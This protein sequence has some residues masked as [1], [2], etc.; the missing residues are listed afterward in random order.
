MTDRE[1]LI[2]LMRQVDAC[3]CNLCVGGEGRFNQS[4]GVLAD[5]LL[6]NGVVVREKGEW[7]VDDKSG[8]DH[9]CP[10]CGREPALEQTWCGVSFCPYCGSDMR[11]GENE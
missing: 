8:G 2:A 3:I 10:V 5:H 9:T 11:K 1:K 4:A 6:A 7:I